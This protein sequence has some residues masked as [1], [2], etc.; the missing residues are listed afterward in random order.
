MVGFDSENWENQVVFW[1]VKAI[2]LSHDRRDYGRSTQMGIIWIPLS[3]RWGAFQA[4]QCP[5][6]HDSCSFA[7]WRWSSIDPV[8]RRARA[9][10]EISL[11]IG[12][13]PRGFSGYTILG[14]GVRLF[15]QLFISCYSFFIWKLFLLSFPPSHGKQTSCR[16][17]RNTSNSSD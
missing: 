3:M 4:S 6:C 16:N 9:K 14:F 2:V 1:P 11:T 17:P 10:S 13:Q 5:R 15:Q 8:P 7:W 12:I